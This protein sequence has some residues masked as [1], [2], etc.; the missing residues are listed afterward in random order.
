MPAA[1]DAPAPAAKAEV[2]TTDEKLDITWSYEGVVARKMDGDTL[3]V[4]GEGLPEIRVLR[5]A[6]PADVAEPE[7]VVTG[8]GDRYFGPV[9]IQCTTSATGDAAAQAEAFCASIRP[10]DHAKLE[11][12]GCEAPAPHDAQVA[13]ALAKEEPAFLDCMRSARGAQPILSVIEGGLQFRFTADGVPVRVGH[14]TDIS[15]LAASRVYDD[16]VFRLL[17]TFT[18]DKA[19]GSEVNARC[20]LRVSLYR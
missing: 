4:T 20:T 15:D 19:D 5:R 8:L 17:K 7:R 6:T 9:W 10:V 12:L 11:V 18:Y 2:W 1:A 13:A 3:V 16:C 14:N